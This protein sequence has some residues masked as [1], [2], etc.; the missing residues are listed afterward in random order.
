M[1]VQRQYF[2]KIIIVIGEEIVKRIFRRR[3]TND[4]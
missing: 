4:D 2:L 3:R 1:Q